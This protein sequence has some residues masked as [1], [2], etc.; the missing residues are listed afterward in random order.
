MKK[1]KYD[2]DEETLSLF[3]FFFFFISKSCNPILSSTLLSSSPSSTVWAS[4][5]KLQ[6]VDQT[7]E[8]Y[9]LK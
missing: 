3:L 4:C 2:F 9:L 7:I 8:T 6:R 5:S 1:R